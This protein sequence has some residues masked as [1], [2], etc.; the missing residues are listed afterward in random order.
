MRSCKEGSSVG[1]TSTIAGGVGPT[2]HLPPPAGSIEVQHEQGLLRVDGWARFKA[3]AR[4]AGAPE[5]GALGCMKGHS[6]RVARQPAQSPGRVE[7]W[8]LLV[9]GHL[10]CD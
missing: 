3:P 7:I 4:I 8:W 9:A 2:H 1:D 5:G 6:G 10:L